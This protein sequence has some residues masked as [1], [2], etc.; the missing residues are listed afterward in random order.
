MVLIGCC[1]ADW[2]RNEEDRHSVSG[3]VFMLA[4]ANLLVDKEAKQCGDLNLR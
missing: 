2:G 4:G 1:D 3:V